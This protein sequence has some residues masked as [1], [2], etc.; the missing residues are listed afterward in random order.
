MRPPV[1]VAGVKATGSF[2][3]RFDFQF[4][5]GAKNKNAAHSNWIFF[6]FPCAAACWPL[7]THSARS[8]PRWEPI[9][10]HSIGQSDQ[11][12]S[13]KTICPSLVMKPFQKSLGFGFEF[14]EGAW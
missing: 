2:K 14:R 4:I 9:W 3:Q 11:E 6:Q 1:L 7:P 12:L 10:Q 13:A 8:H 5:L